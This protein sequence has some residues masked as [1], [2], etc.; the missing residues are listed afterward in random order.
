MC[1][2]EWAILT[3]A[4]VWELP[5][6]CGKQFPVFCPGLTTSYEDHYHEN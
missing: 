3:T 4:C 1:V 6:K 5:L 2:G